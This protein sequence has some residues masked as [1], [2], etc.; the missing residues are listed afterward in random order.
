MEKI[1]ILQ[2]RNII[3]EDLK[4]VVKEIN[5]EQKEMV[6]MVVD[7]RKKVIAIKNAIKFLKSIK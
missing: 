3:I 1:E 6:I 5:N 2:L 7:D 4:E